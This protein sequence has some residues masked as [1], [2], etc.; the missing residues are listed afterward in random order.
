[1]LK[2]EAEARALHD[3]RGLRSSILSAPVVVGLVVALAT[4]LFSDSLNS[5][6]RAEVR[7][8]VLVLYFGVDNTEVGKRSQILT[9]AETVLLRDDPALI[10]WIDQERIVV[11]AH[12]ADLDQEIERNDLA[13]DGLQSK[14]EKLEA[15]LR[16]LRAPVQETQSP[17]NQE[18]EKTLALLEAAEEKEKILRQQR[19]ARVRKPK[20][21]DKNQTGDPLL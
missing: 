16:G 3:R 21:S 10:D 9:F 1:M 11:E 7:R 19:N 14:I 15:E 20:T 5:R 2:L 8:D 17:A 13:I 12:M 6:T 4:W 18:R